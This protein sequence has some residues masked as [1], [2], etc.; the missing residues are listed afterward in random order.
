MRISDIYSISR[1]HV[2]MAEIVFTIFL[3]IAMVMKNVSGGENLC[4]F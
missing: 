3:C 1:E 4:E 2:V